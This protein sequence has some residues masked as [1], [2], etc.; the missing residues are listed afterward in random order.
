MH[1]FTPVHFTQMCQKQVHT[2]FLSIGYSLMICFIAMT[3]AC[4]QAPAL[5]DPLAAGWKGEQVCEVLEDNATIRVLK[6][7]LAPG[8][9]HEKHYHKPH[10]AYAIA[11]STFQMR[12]TNGVRDAVMETGKYYYSSGVDWHEPINIGDS[13]AV[14]LIIEPK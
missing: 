7:T 14:F 13:T 1:A 3:T 5:P 10:F 4:Q 2:F 11:G 6:C 12:D 9:G 8:V